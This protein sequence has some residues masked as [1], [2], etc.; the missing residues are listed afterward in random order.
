MELKIQNF[1]DELKQLYTH[2]YFKACAYLTF[3]KSDDPHEI[4]RQSR[5][6]ILKM[7][8]TLR[9]IRDE[10][11]FYNKENKFF[12]DESRKLSRIR[13]ATSVIETIK[14]LLKKYSKELKGEAFTEIIS[15]LEEERNLETADF[16]KRNVIEEVSSNLAGHEKRLK[17]LNIEINSFKQMKPSITRV[18]KRG[19]KAFKKVKETKHSDDFHQ[20][21]KRAK[22]LRIQ[23]KIMIKIWPGVLKVWAKELFELTEILGFERDLMMLQNKLTSNRKRTKE[24]QSTELLST[25]IIGQREK[26]RI[27]AI[28]AGEKLYALSSKDFVR[29]I[30]ASWKAHQKQLNRR[31]I[32]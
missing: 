25:L 16:L 27:R 2:E 5:K 28:S 7:R 14:L 30:E 11:N 8:A 24:L 1:S 15:F 20:W 12:R 4:V 3:K 13:D 21:R 6:S 22:Y 26:L 32:K 19:V 29:L 23:L 9:L 18:Y 17:S 31:F 10:V